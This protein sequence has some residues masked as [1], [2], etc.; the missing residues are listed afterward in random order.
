MITHANDAVGHFGLDLLV[1]APDWLGPAAIMAAT[2]PGPSKVNDSGA[3]D[4]DQDFALAHSKDDGFVGFGAGIPLTVHHAP[5]DA[6]EV[7]RPALDALAAAGAEL[8]SEAALGLEHIGVVAWVDVPAGPYAGFGSGPAGPDV[9]VGECLATVYPGRL[10]SGT[11]KRIRSD[12]GGSVHGALPSRRDSP[13][14]EA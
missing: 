9:V 8:E 3:V 2:V 14:V 4:V 10:G 7:A 1:R 11:M 6:D 13:A 5:G 12:Q